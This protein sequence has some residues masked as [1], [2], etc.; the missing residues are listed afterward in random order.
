VNL[1]ADNANGE[2]SPSPFY[3]KFARLTLFHYQCSKETTSR[4]ISAVFQ[5]ASQRQEK[6]DTTKQRCVVFMVSLCLIKSEKS[7]NPK[8]FSLFADCPDAP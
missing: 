4:E 2:D 5:K 8:R 7:L 3:R 1:L 6:V